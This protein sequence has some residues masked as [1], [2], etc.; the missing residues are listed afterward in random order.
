M[1]RAGRYAVRQ[2][3]LSRRARKQYLSLPEKARRRVKAAL[4]AFAA[5][6][7]GDVKRLHG[8]GGR[9][10]LFRLRI[11]GYRIIIYAG[12]EEP[13]TLRVIQILSREQAYGWL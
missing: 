5:S 11:G 10:D 4:T 12:D 13:P 1:D 2:V 9:E 6:G 3:L 7:R 8:V